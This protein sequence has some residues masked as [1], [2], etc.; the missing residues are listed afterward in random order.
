VEVCFL[1]LTW[2]HGP[3]FRILLVVLSSTSDTNVDDDD[4]DK[5]KNKKVEHTRNEVP[6]VGKAM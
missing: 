3:K 1:W 2:I 5:K 6:A 4:D